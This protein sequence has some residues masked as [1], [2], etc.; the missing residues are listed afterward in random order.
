MLIL[1]SGLPAVG[2]S[3]LADALGQHLGAPVLSVDPIEAAI[4]RCGIE[5]SFQ[6]GVAAYEV[7]ASLAAHQ[8]AL[9]LDV[10]GDAVNSLEVGREMWRKAAREVGAPWRVIHV[11]CSDVAAHRSR[12]AR[13]QRNLPGFA[14]PS[15]ADVERRSQ[16]FEPWPEPTLLVDGA[17]DLGSNLERA[18][19]FVTR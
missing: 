3:V 5:R 6:T 14:E 18:I 11:V 12:L 17:D 7:A 1:M 8:L 10:I 13:R 15:W 9:G 19:D 16:E 4:L 2:K